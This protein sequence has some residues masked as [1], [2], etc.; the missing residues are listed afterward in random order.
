MTADEKPGTAEEGMGLAKRG[1]F[2]ELSTMWPGQGLSIQ[3]DEALFQGR[4]KFQASWC[5][6]RV[7]ALI[8]VCCIDRVPLQDICVFSSQAFGKVLLLDGNEHSVLLLAPV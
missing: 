4:S 6:P 7:T 5:Q 8:C 2:T 1:W 3:V